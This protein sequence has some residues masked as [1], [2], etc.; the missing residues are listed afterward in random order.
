L[1][2][3]VGGIRARPDTTTTIFSATAEN[4]GMTVPSCAGIA[5]NSGVTNVSTDGEKWPA[6]A[7][8]YG[9][10]AGSCSGT[11]GTPDMIVTPG[12]RMVWRCLSV[13]F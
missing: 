1:Q 12:G 7:E 2:I 5:G 4:S 11:R 3:L 13:M 10:I 9:M 6:T 8:N